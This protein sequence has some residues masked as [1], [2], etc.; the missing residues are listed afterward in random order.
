[1]S[2]FVSEDAVSRKD[3]RGRNERF[4]TQ[5]SVALCVSDLLFGTNFIYNNTYRE[6]GG[7]LKIRF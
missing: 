5:G 7:E 4:L 1:M 3:G 6:M 2:V